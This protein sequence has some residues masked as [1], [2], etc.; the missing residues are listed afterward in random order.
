MRVR[1]LKLGRCAL[2]SRRSK[3]AP[4]AGAWIET[5]TSSGSF[6]GLVRSRP[7]RVRG[8][9]RSVLI[10]FFQVSNVAPY[11]GAWIETGGSSR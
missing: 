5:V 4:Y 11:A 1:G 7:M 3:V 10:Y 6:R 8:L 9:K 2:Y